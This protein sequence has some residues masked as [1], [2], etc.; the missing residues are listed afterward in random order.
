MEAV[1]DSSPRPSTL[2]PPPMDNG[3]TATRAVQRF[4]L[5]RSFLKA[6]AAEPEPEPE[7]PAKRT[8]RLAIV[9]TAKMAAFDRVRRERALEKKKDKEERVI[10][11][12]R[13]PVE[14]SPQH[15]LTAAWALAAS[16]SL[17]AAASFASAAAYLLFFPHL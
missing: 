5:A 9:E 16:V 8:M 6:R 13:T 7:V 4:D 17:V 1:T 12:V 3:A 10:V 2:S 11:L 15:A 14:A